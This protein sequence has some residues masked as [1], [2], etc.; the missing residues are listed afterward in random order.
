LHIAG[1][2]TRKNG[3]LVSTSQHIGAYL[4]RRLYD[5]GVRHVFG[6]PGDYVLGFFDQLVH[7]DLQVI[8]TCDEQGAAF[9]ADAYAR[10]RGTGAVCITYC[11]GGLKVAN[12]T[13]QAFAEKVPLVVISGAPGVK[14]RVRNPLLHHKARDFDS[15]HKVFEQLTVASTV[16]TDPETACREIERVLAAML[17]YKRPVYIELPRDMIS[18]PANAVSKPLERQDTGDP[19]P[20][21]EALHE[22][23]EMINASRRPVILAGIEL[24]RFGLQQALVEL[25]EK[26]S[27]P[28]AATLLSKSVIA[29][30]HPLYLGVYEG[31]MG[32]Q[33]VRDYVESSDCLIL[34]GAFLSDIDLAIYTAHLD[35]KRSISVTSEKASIR[36]H[37]YDEVRLRD[38]VHGLIDADIGRREPGAI[39]HPTPPAPFSA[40]PGERIT[41]RRLFQCLNAFV[42]DDTVVIAEPGDA[43]F[44]G[45]DL[46][47]HGSTEFLSPAYYLSM[48]YAVPAS[49][50]AQLANPRLRPLVL[51]GDG[52]F[53]MT[54]ME[55]ATIARFGLSPIVV[56]FNNR[57]YG[58]ERPM[59]E[60][61]FNDVH[62]WRYSR[63]PDV[64]GAGRG[65]D[66]ETEKQLDEALRLSR[67]YTQGFCI[68]DV[69][70]D[71]HDNSPAL[72]R[73]TAALGK[74][75]K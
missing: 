61:P 46:F 68:L 44:G 27:I 67:E 62:V 53:Q 23:V 3:V 11:V 8:N 40:V 48:G 38:F 70:L 13:A 57:G 41:V 47:I 12:P 35:L 73:L 49:L 56:V 43:L 55:L 26:T 16:L 6:V 20:L 19:D 18:A 14:E 1:R 10:M 7:S 66:I 33:D 32:F 45:A 24:H 2:I 37:N 65:F 39:P 31:G 17:R 51:V 52:A 29:E 60:G 71:P 69:H 5:L 28:V 34:L 75:V 63:I 58:T 54:G 9:A 30:R 59:L 72:Q 36:N 64:L 74:R 25:V 21:R 15:Q 4:I 22:A 50:G 42:T